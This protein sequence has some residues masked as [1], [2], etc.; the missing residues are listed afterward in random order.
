[1]VDDDA[2]KILDAMFFVK[3]LSTMVEVLRMCR[4]DAMGF[5]GA[6]R[7]A[8]QVPHDFEALTKPMR[9]YIADYISTHILGIFSVSTALLVCRLLEHHGID[10]TGKV[11]HSNNSLGFEM[12]SASHILVNYEC[13]M[14]NDL[15]STQVRCSRRT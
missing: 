12:S 9:K 4:C 14:S 8:P 6:S 2:R 7:K 15:L 1:M 3:K 5:R 11:S 10:V 13:I